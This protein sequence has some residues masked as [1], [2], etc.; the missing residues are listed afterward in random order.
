[1]KKFFILDTN[2]LIHDPNAMWVFAEHNVGIPITV[3][4]ELDHLKKGIEPKN[5]SARE[6][7]RKLSKL[8]ENLENPTALSASLGDDHGCISILID[9]RLH[10]IVKKLF[11]DNIPDH[12]I[13]STALNWRDNIILDG[14]DGN[15]ILVSKDTNL[16]MKCRAA[17]LE[18][19]DYEFDSVQTVDLFNPIQEVSVPEMYI[20]KMYKDASG[21]VDTDYVA[22]MVEPIV[23]QGLI[24]KNTNGSALVTV[25]SIN[26]SDM[27]VRLVKNTLAYGIKPLNA[28]QSIFMDLLLNDNIPLV[29]CTGKAGTGKTLLALASS[30]EQKKNYR[31]IY[32]SRP[33]IPMGKDIG[34]LPGDIEDKIDP[35][36][37]PLWDNLSF[38]KSQLKPG[39]ARAKDIVTMQ[40]K[41]K[42]IIS[43]LTFIRGRSLPKV[44]FIIDEAQNLSPHEIKTIVTRAGKGAKIVFT[45]DIQQIDTPYLDQRSN[46]LSY[47]I[48]KM[49]GNKLMSHVHLVKGVRSELADVASKLL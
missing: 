34:Y 17:Q 33:A 28:E 38:I 42:L 13:L 32:L 1:M 46:G 6:A 16:R 31:Q 27:D 11:S 49:R 8:F 25:K 22:G 23:N 36:M 24:L 14:G 4:E 43:A 48:A 37:Q 9:A 21:F 5:F 3:F 20:D 39:D 35:Y 15:V 19:E 26:Q 45:G 10:P 40:T 2:V 7:L 47:M 18:A 30:L 29:A 41:K 44:F 12:K